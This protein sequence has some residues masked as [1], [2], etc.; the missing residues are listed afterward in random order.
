MMNMHPHVCLFDYQ[1]LGIGYRPTLFIQKPKVGR[2]VNTPWA[3][4]T[5]TPNEA[6]PSVLMVLEESS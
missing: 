4:N 3:K 1:I 2:V 5:T 6:L